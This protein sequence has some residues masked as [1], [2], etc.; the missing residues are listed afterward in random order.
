M[1]LVFN[2]ASTTHNQ[3]FINRHI[4]REFIT[5]TPAGLTEKLFGAS[6]A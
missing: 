4:Q 1:A 5:I 6:V 2:T 3:V